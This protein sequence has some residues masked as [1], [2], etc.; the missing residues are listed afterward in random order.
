MG[1]TFFIILDGDVG[2]KVPT[3]FE[4]NFGSY[5]AVLN[6]LIENYCDI[7][8]LKDTVSHSIKKFI[9]LIGIEVFRRFS[10]KKTQE[11][12]IFIEDLLKEV[13]NFLEQYGIKITKKIKDHQRF[14]K[15]LASAIKVQS[16]KEIDED[17]LLII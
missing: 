7:Q 15:D 6:F 11:L 4:K 1:D 17:Q 8:I 14:F 16:K 12:I 3:P 9:D 2:V 10:F 13:P 5:L